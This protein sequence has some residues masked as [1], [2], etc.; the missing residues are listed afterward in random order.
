MAL[1]NERMSGGGRR[2]RRCTFGTIK[3]EHLGTNGA[4][5]FIAVGFCVSEFECVG[6]IGNDWH[7]RHHQGRAPGHGLAHPPLSRCVSAFWGFSGSG[8]GWGMHQG[9]Q[10]PADAIM[11]GSSPHG[12]L[13]PSLCSAETCSGRASAL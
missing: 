10:A 9:V 5:A 2:D 12:C 8:D 1:S 13:E 11:H 3:D 6:P 7:F 4:P